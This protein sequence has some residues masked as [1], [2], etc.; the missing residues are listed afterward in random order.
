MTS[1]KKQLPTFDFSRVGKKWQDE[2]QASAEIATRA[3]FTIQRPLRKQRPDEGDDEYGDYI[4]SFYDAKDA[5]VDKVSAMQHTQTKLMA[6]VLV[7]VPHEWLLADAPEALDWSDEKSLD[8]IQ[9]D[10]YEE[11]LNLVQTGEARKIAKK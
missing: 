4:Q 3:G 1:T 7:S 6:Q 10:H 9:S 8:Y 11:L 2:F 5:A